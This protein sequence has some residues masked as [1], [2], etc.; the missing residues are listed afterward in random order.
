MNGESLIKITIHSFEKSRQIENAMVPS[1]QRRNWQHRKS[2][3]GVGDIY[4]SKI[5]HQQTD[6]STPL[7][8][9]QYFHYNGDEKNT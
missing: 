5:S 7:H 6:I 2:M 4:S 3:N 8:N 1:R 9:I